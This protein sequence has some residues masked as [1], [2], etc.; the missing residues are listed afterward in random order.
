[1]D[2]ARLYPDRMRLI[3]T[4]IHSCTTLSMSENIINTLLFPT[5]VLDYQKSYLEFPLLSP[6][7]IKHAHFPRIYRFLGHGRI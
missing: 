3:L 6:H 2:A 4:S 1:M 7:M 5:I